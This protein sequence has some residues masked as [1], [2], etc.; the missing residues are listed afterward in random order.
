[1]NRKTF[2]YE[3]KPLEAKDINRYLIIFALAFLICAG[4]LYLDFLKG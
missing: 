3:R 4:L 2:K 1:M